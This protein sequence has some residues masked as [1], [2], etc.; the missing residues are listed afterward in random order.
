MRSETRPGVALLGAQGQ[1]GVALV[2][3]LE[4]AAD[5]RLAACVER[6]GHPALGTM[7]A[8]VALTDD[9]EGAVAAAELV[10]DF[11]LP[12]AT[13]RAVAVAARL[14]RPFVS[15]VTGLDAAQEAEL[16]AAAQIIP[17]VHAPNMSLGVHL[18]E[19]LLREAARRLP[20]EYDIELVE[21]HHRRKRD[22]PSGTARRWA[23]ALQAERERLEPI[24]GRRGETGPRPPQEL[25]IHAL[26]GGDV[27]GE[28]RVIFAGPG[29]RIVFVHQAESRAAFVQ[30]VLRAARFALERSPGRYGM[31]AVLGIE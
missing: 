24:Y 7:I 3:A 17:V 15:G 31:A 5:L 4:E 19:H 6:A 13:A 21:M 16:A 26:R 23:A 12:A 14:G 9:L 22:A 28:H 10:I 25:G 20:L 2:A 27:V 1:M 30:G 11:S 29:E 8:G 18:L